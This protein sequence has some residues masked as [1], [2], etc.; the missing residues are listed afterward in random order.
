MAPHVAASIGEQHGRLRGAFGAIL[1]AV[2]LALLAGSGF[3]LRGEPESLRFL[4]AAFGALAAIPGIGP[5]LAKG[6]VGSGDGLR[7]VLFHH[8]L[9]FTL[10]AVWWLHGRQHPRWPRWTA[11]AA[12]LLPAVLL[13]LWLAPALDDG[14]PF[15]GRGSAHFAGGGARLGRDLAHAVRAGLGVC[16]TRSGGASRRATVARRARTPGGLPRVPRGR[17][18]TFRRARSRAVGCASC[19]RGNVFSLQASLAHDGMFIVPGNLADGRSHLR[20]RLSRRRR[21]ARP[22]LVDD[23][24][25]RHCHGEPPGVGRAARRGCAPHRENRPLA[26]RQPSASALCAVPPRRAE[27]RARTGHRASA[28]RRLH[29]LPRDLRSRRARGARALSRRARRRN[30]PRAWTRC[31]APRRAPRHRVAGRQCAVLRLPQSLG[32]HFALL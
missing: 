14:L 6:L 20:R 24:A 27:D 31:G 28:G 29:R 13:S 26:G 30:E 23:H 15:G 3:A 1:G 32:A 10:L 4:E 25:C 2:A 9:T 16:R 8:A 18:R 12:V 21:R 7:V 5:L 11:I 17:D 22:A 19:H